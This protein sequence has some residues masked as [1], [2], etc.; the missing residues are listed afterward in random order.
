M[1]R[2][3]THLQRLSSLRQHH[4][5]D[6]LPLKSTGHCLETMSQR[7]YR[8]DHRG[9]VTSSRLLMLISLLIPQKRQ[10]K[11]LSGKVER[12][13]RFGTH[14]IARSCGHRWQVALGGAWNQGSKIAF[15]L[16]QMVLV[17][18]T[19]GEASPC[20][21]SKILC[22]GRR[23]LMNGKMTMTLKTNAYHNSISAL[24]QWSLLT[25]FLGR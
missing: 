3:L 2:L 12:T 1:R 25:V 21:Y 16:P 20:P 22:S 5:Y 11:L 9:S 6:L 18:P 23:W 14:N 15:V 10:T 8:A 7:L 13:R 19:V 4:L 17:V 24:L